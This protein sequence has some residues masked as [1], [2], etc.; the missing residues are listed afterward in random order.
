MHGFPNGVSTRIR[1]GRKTSHI[2]TK[3]DVKVNYLFDFSHGIR[4]K[5]RQ[6]VGNNPK[7]VIQEMFVDTAGTS[8][9]PPALAE[10]LRD[11]LPTLEVFHL[12]FFWIQ[13]STS[14]PE[15]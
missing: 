10:N 14:L 13:I 7:D 3:N 2:V 1:F 8:L 6:G 12:C 4:F 11:Q 15:K 9:V 5:C